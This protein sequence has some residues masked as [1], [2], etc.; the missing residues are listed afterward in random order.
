MLFIIG[1][2]L[3]LG[4]IEISGT[5][6]RLGAHVGSPLHVVLPSK[7]VH[8]DAPSSDVPR[9]H[10]DTGEQHHRTRALKM[11]RHSQSVHTEGFIRCGVEDSGLLDELFPNGGDFFYFVRVN[12]GYI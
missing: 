2:I 3:F 10:G 9:H 11:F 12:A 4:Y 8:P 1:L 7:R 6:V 5:L